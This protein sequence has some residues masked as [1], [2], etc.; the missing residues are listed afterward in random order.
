MKT[1]NILYVAVKALISNRD[2]KVLVL[3]QSDPTITGHNR[4][5]PPGGIVE[6]GE[7][8]EEALVREVQEETGVKAKVVRLFDVGEWYA[9]RGDDVMQF[10]GLFYECRIESEDFVIEESEASKAKWVGLEDL[11]HTDIIAPS[12]VIIRKFLT[13]K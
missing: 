9:E 11:D 6:L 4:C 7:S 8:L 13:R 10:V 12:D 1:P 5:H 2:G 3:K